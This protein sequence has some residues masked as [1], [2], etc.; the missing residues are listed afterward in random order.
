MDR[1]YRRRQGVGAIVVGAIFGSFLYLHLAGMN[2]PAC[3]ARFWRNRFL[4]KF[5]RRS[6]GNAL[7]EENK[8]KREGFALVAAGLEGD[9]CRAESALR[10]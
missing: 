4:W 6:I 3:G 9:W 5:E 8:G 2:F 7:T 1:F 10:C